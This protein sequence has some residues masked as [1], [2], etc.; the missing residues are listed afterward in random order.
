MKPSGRFYCAAGDSHLQ[1]DC[2]LFLFQSLIEGFFIS[3]SCILAGIATLFGVSVPQLGI[4]YFL[5]F[6][7][8][9]KPEYYG[10]F[11]SLSE[12]F[13]ISYY[14]LTLADVAERNVSVPQ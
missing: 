11:Q 2:H 14:T 1:G 5:P 4:F 8:E 13:F 3:Y 10:E 7:I 9:L 6:T 12:G